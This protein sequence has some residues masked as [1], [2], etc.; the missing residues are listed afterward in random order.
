MLV[1]LFPRYVNA[2]SSLLDTGL[3]P[4]FSDRAAP[5]FRDFNSAVGLLGLLQFKR[6]SSALDRAPIPITAPRVGPNSGAVQGWHSLT[7]SSPH[8][9]LS[10]AP[11]SPIPFFLPRLRTSPNLCSG[12][13]DPG[14]ICEKAQEYQ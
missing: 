9:R 14:W 5:I 2:G 4:L 8:F 6:P 1:T 11:A 3:L 7:T 10:P 12:W 13:L